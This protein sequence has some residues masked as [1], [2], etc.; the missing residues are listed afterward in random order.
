MHWTW[1]YVVVY[2]LWCRSGCPTGFLPNISTVCTASR[3]HQHIFHVLYW[4][5]ILWK[6]KTSSPP[7][8]LTPCLFLRLP[9]HGN[10]MLFP[11]ELQDKQVLFL[12]KVTNLVYFVIDMEMDYKRY[13]FQRTDQ[14]T[15]EVILYSG[16]W[17]IH[18]QAHGDSTYLPWLVSVMV[19][20]LNGIV[21]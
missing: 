11:P 21:N 6:S 2:M 8:P 10:T 19:A 17:W 20:V 1:V 12:Y 13:H 15:C 3:R 18:S 4:D 14:K 9:H 5:W 7:C 16:G